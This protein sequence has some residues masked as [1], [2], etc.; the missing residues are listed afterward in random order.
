MTVAWSW[1]GIALLAGA[2]LQLGCLGYLL[3]RPGV[4]A[5]GGLA[6]VLAAVAVWDLAH[7]FEL[8]VAAN[9]AQRV[10]WGGVKY[11]G[12]AALPAA[13]WTFVVQYAG[14]RK[15]LPWPAAVALA[16]VP[17]AVLGILVLPSTSWL[18]HRYRI[19]TVQADSGPLFWPFVAYTGATLIGGLVYLATALLHV[20]PIYRRQT[21][22]L[23]VFAM[24]PFAAILAFN[25]GWG[26]SHAIDPTPLAFS[27]AG[28]LLVWGV[29]RFRLLP[30]F[31]LVRSHIFT[32]LSDGA[33]V[34]DP[35]RRVVDVNAA[36]A[37]L[38]GRIPAAVIGHDVQELLPVPVD[39]A[40]Q[41][42][43]TAVHDESG[44]L[45]VRLCP[46]PDRAGRLAGWLLLATDVTA[47]REA[48][49]ARQWAEV[50]F[51]AAFDTALVGMA[52]ITAR[53]RFVE[54][55]AGLI[56]LTGCPRADLLHRALDE[57]TEPE[58]WED[59][60]RA[61]CDVAT[62]VRSRVRWQ[63]RLRRADGQRRWVAAGL[64]AIERDADS[65][66][67]YLLLQAEDI[68]ER[69]EVEQRLAYAARHDELT[70]LANRALLLQQL[71]R[72]L[73]NRHQAG[74]ELALLLLDLDGF[75]NINDLFGHAAGD[76]LLTAVA[77]RLSDTVRCEAT[78]A[79][80]G[81]DEFVVLLPQIADPDDAL[82]VSR[83]LLSKLEEP[84][85][86]RRGTARISASVGIA[87]AG[88]TTTPES[89]LSDADAAMYLAK[90]HG[91]ARATRLTPQ[92]RAEQLNRI[93]LEQGLQHALEQGQL[94]LAY[95]PIYPLAGGPASS[96]EALLRWRHPSRGL[97]LPDTFLP[98][99]E[100]ARLIAEI[101]AWVL[102]EALQQL[103]RWS[104]TSPAVRGLVVAVNL[105][106]PLVRDPHLRELVRDALRSS[107]CQ[108]H[109]LCLEI[110]ETTLLDD[111]GA[112]LAALASLHQEGV[113]IAVDDFGTGYS[114]LSRI[115]SL[116]IDL[117]KID[118]TFVWKAVNDDTDHRILRLVIDL[119]HSLQLRT[120]AEGV[121][122]PEQLALLSE[123]GCDLV[124]GNYLGEPVFPEETLVCEWP[125]PHVRSKDPD[126]APPRL[127]TA[128]PS[129]T[130]P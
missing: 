100:H 95:Q 99:A 35:Q 2:A 110:T 27:A 117:V 16:V 11:V 41:G 89:L 78:V 10:W 37:R 101:D 7:G 103:R 33:F 18:I 22:T 17:V 66:E 24:L 15:G 76:E 71:E 124:Q 122:G 116:P 115:R 59:D 130:P 87:T 48:E 40:A 13:W 1:G 38:L 39:E 72:G 93:Q 81:G 28:P 53:G 120:I 121:E 109:Q 127:P 50:R 47:W 85:R 80:L 90:R 29:L 5:V 113:C 92:L 106:T 12:I 119:A 123:L 98:V 32:S 56:E 105:S 45:A 54:V 43:A 55:N 108:P 52:L 82:T 129:A 128:S 96:V 19:G 49:A 57:L 74:G 86:L 125:P 126:H 112:A 114:S 62:G 68:T 46:I 44:R 111:D 73:R 61:L 67:Q 51:R 63:T 91:R 60:R 4:A 97:L 31:P 30:L 14:R 26:P 21:T 102:Q 84:Y 42:Q 75:K 23:I 34:L 65:G 20:S 69:R 6:A 36:G 64:T 94:A 79:R 104:A 118:K 25:E 70:G 77:R 3:R 107:S 83:R 9:L 8:F 58:C 88:P